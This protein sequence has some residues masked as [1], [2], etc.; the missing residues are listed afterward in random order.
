MN[1]AMLRFRVRSMVSISLVM[2]LRMS[3]KGVASKYLSGSRLVFS[4]MSVRMRLLTV[5]ATVAMMKCCRKFI[6]QL[7]P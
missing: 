2:R 4:V 5:G 7:I 6:S 3:P 1:W